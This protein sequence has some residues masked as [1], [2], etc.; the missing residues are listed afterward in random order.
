MVLETNGVM[1]LLLR[2]SMLS[3]LM[4]NMRKV[5]PRI[6]VL[7]LDLFPLLLNSLRKMMYYFFTTRSILGMPVKLI[8]DL[9][10]SE[11]L[12]SDKVVST[13]N[14]KVVDHPHPYRLAW[15][16]N[17]NTVKVTKHCEVPWISGSYQAIAL[18]DDAVDACHLLLG[19]LWQFD[20]KVTWDGHTN[21]YIVSTT[22]NEFISCLNTQ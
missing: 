1:I 3:P 15:L 6:I 8:I 19:H 20:S 22:T 5:F 12:V 13:L 4:M 14:F 21:V 2:I 18:C 11:N 10:A 16:S 17:A 9:A 7:F